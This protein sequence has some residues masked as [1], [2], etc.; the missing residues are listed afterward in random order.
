VEQVLTA[1]AQALAEAGATGARH[2]KSAAS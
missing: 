2:V 1:T